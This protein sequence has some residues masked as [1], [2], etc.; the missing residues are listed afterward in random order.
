M[1]QRS[2]ATGGNRAVASSVST[3]TVSVPRP[4]WGTVREALRGS[5]QDYSISSTIGTASSTT[6]RP[7]GA[8]V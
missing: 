7:I 1:V 2:V 3:T 8:S 6:A 5:H 4:I